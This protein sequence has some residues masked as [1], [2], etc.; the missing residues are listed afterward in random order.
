MEEGVP[1]PQQGSST[2]VA[3][4][5]A[6]VETVPPDASPSAEI[7]PLME[8]GAPEQAHVET[9]PPDAA[10]T[11]AEIIPSMEEGAPVRE[12]WSSTIVAPEQTH[13]E[14]VPLDA[15]SLSAEIIPSMEGIPVPEAPPKP[16]KR[17]GL[18]QLENRNFLI[19]EMPAPKRRKQ[20]QY[21]MDEVLDEDVVKQYTY[22]LVFEEQADAFHIAIDMMRPNNSQVDPSDP[23]ATKNVVSRKRFQQIEQQL[24]TQFNKLQLFGSYGRSR[25]PRRFTSGWI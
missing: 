20:Q 2:I 19:L 13:V 7:I 4:G 6:H 1:V 22:L 21:P 11:S 5:Q 16:T 25:S 14:T 8:E 24:G 17:P 12:Q 9:V 10:S 3:P 18:P 23:G 15:A